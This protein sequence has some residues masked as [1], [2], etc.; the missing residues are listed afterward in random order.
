MHAKPVFAAST[1]SAVLNRRMAAGGDVRLWAALRPVIKRLMDFVGAVIL[2]L[3]AA[4]VFLLVA[5]AV[6]VD[7]GPVFFTHH[8]VGRG[9]REFG[10][11]KFRSMY[12]DAGRR[13]AELLE[14]DP[15][16]RVEWITR[17]K[18]RRD[19]RITPL[20][21]LLRLSSV[22]E[23]PQLLNV[24]AGQ[25]SFVGPRPVVREELEKFYSPANAVGEYLSVRPGITGPWQVSGRSDAD[26]DKRIAL[27][28]AYVREPSLRNDLSILA[29]T[30]VSVLQR[31]GAC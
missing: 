31:R 4:P 22:D 26:Y 28:V 29:S 27:D 14:Q 3:C 2:L 7:G 13:L 9:G 23:L 17:R 25:M 6:S 19:T 30:V 18:L 20:G 15:A 1:L 16:A 5:V 8:R 11:L 24:L 12:T 21:R 10:C